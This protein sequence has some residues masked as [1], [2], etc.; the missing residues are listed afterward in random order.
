MLLGLA[1]MISIIQ[2]KYSPISLN[3]AKRVNYKNTI[4]NIIIALLTYFIFD[5]NEIAFIISLVLNYI[6]NLIF[7]DLDEFYKVLFSFFVFTITSSILGFYLGSFYWVRGSEMNLLF[8]IIFYII[9][10][11]KIGIVNGILN[12]VKYLFS[13]LRAP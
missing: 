7:I 4:Y 5:Y 2:K 11:T 1:L 8:I 10:G 9:L 13:F 12:F 3:N 6:I